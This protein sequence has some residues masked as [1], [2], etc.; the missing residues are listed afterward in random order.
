[1]STD[2]IEPEAAVAWRDAVTEAVTATSALLGADPVALLDSVTF[3]SNLDAHTG[4]P[5]GDELTAAVTAAT[6]SYVRATEAVAQVTETDH[7][8]GRVLEAKGSDGAGGRVFR[9]QI[10]KYGD[11]KNG[12]RYTENVMRRDVARYEGAKAYDRHRTAADLQS[13]TIQGIVGQYRG[14]EATVT[15]LEA[16]LHLLPGA[17]HAAEALDASIVAQAAGL[18][19]LVGLSHDV[20]ADF[21]PIQAGGRRLMEATA[22]QAVNSVDLVAE[23]SAGGKAVRVLAGGTDP[24]DPTIEHAEEE[25][26]VTVAPEAVLAAIKDLTPEQLAAVGLTQATTTTTTTTEPAAAP[27]AAEGATEAVDAYAKASY[28]GRSMI[29]QKVR[30]AVPPAALRAVTE[31]VI[32]ALPARVTEADVDAQ[33]GAY[34]ATLAPLEA[35]GLVP[36]VTAVVTQEATDKKV[37][38]LNKFFEGNGQGYRSFRAAYTD[39]TGARPHGLGEDFN[40]DILRESV[41]GHYD[42]SRSTESRATESLAAADWAQVLGSAVNRR[43]IAEYNRPSLQ[44]WRKIVSSTPPINDFRTQRIGRV[45]GYG[46][47]P[48]V[49]EGQPYQPLTSPGDEE[50]TYAVTKRGGTEDLTLEMIANDDV[51]AI[52][53]IPVSLG[54][55]AAQ[56][57]YRFVW[58]IFTTNAATSYDSIALFHT[59]HNNTAAGALSQTSLT[60]GRVAMRSQAA[61]GDTSDI[62][63]IVPK[64]L[65]VPNE[66]EELAFQL[67]RS[68][69]AV[70]STAAGPSDTPN[71]HQG[72]EP[73]VIDYYT[74]A[75]DWYLVADPMDVPTIEIGFYLGRQEPD[76][77]TQSDQSVGSMWNSDKLSY[78][79][80]HV[81]S[82]TALDHRAF[83]RGAN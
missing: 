57:L 43:L 20:L 50:A 26:D 80:R 78:K 71:I 37:D 15:G 48:A 66:L 67:S 52:Q 51:R 17:G 58:D 63:S 14:V 70:P 1:M 7:Q 8:D 73:I 22:I 25:D 82:G 16:D 2:L 3:L 65:I 74:D 72:I 21:R 38:A 36:T 62:L 59:S 11:S 13:S 42:S 55:A 81:Y 4:L 34:K 10:I 28:I 5:P 33:I 32:S 18:P 68:V 6:E 64:F 54:R 41:G 77:F 60:A 83:Y 53:R 56:T 30:D 31:A 76:L 79:I 39:F 35:A 24:T 23:P 46:T 40:R 45:G 75:N 12:R 49:N 69:V 9:V 44:S 61:Y 27:A 19:P 29:E 47:L